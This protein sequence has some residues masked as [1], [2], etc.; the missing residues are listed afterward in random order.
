MPRRAPSRGWSRRL[1]SVVG[2]VQQRCRRGCSCKPARELSDLVDSN[3]RDQGRRAGWPRSPSDAGRRVDLPSAEGVCSSSTAWA[4]IPAKPNALTP[5]RRG[6]SSSAWIQGRATGFKANALRGAA[7]SGCVVRVQ[8]RRQDAVIK[9]QRR[10]DQ[11]GHA[12]RRHGMADHRRDGPQ[13]AASM[14][15]GGKDGVQGRVARP[16]RPRAR[17]AR[18]PRPA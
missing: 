16:G 15:E 7:S 18:G 1:L 3:R 5:A 12:G 4:L 10:L 13:S 17:P 14:R 9:R 6:A 2:H 11:S 8:G